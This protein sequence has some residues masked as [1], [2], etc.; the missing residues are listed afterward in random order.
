MT[1]LSYSDLLPMPSEISQSI[2][3]LISVQ[4]SIMTV[5]SVLSSHAIIYT[6][7]SF[8]KWKQLIS[9]SLIVS[10]HQTLVQVLI[11]LYIFHSIDF[12][13]IQS[14]QLQ[15]RMLIKSFKYDTYI[16][17]YYLFKNFYT[18]SSSQTLS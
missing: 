8:M 2:H 4:Y 17:Y 13:S 3:F 1:F 10:S 5:L 9:S 7:E 6:R 18:A 16:I 12:L 14:F 11:D 15:I